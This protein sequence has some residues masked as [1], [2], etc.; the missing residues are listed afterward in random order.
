MSPASLLI[1]AD[2][3]YLTDPTRSRWVKFRLK[4]IEDGGYLRS[5][6]LNKGWLSVRFTNG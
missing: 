4:P 1:W 3:V 5:P 2:S 6:V